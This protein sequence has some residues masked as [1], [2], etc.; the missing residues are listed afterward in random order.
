MKTKLAYNNVKHN[1]IIMSPFE[2]VYMQ[3]L[4]HVMELALVENVQE[5]SD[6]S[7]RLAKQLSIEG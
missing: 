5:C 3:S 4:M 7:E 6:S 2:F 1:V